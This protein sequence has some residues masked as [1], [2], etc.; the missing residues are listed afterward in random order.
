MNL[1]QVITKAQAGAPI[2]LGDTEFIMESDGVLSSEAG[3]VTV[4]QL[5]SEAWSEAAPEPSFPEL[6]QGE[7][8]A[9]FNTTKGRW[10]STTN[11]EKHIE[12]GSEVAIFSLSR[13]V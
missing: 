7:M 8:Y 11:V 4:E 5:A 10:V 6:Q 13:H 12:A 9:V 1:L 3:V 2:Y